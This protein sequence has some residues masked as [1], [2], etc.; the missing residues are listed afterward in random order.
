MQD[1]SPSER[2]EIFYEAELERLRKKHRHE[3]PW[4]CTQCGRV[5][6]A[7]LVY[8]GG[9]TCSECGGRFEQEDD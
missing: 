8:A 1:L 4:R 7:Y 6:P 3:P 2:R 5:K 9:D